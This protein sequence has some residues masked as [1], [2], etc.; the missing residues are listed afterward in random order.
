MLSGNA[1]LLE[2]PPKNL[3][4]THS[5]TESSQTNTFHFLIPEYSSQM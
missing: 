4:S 5:L 1:Y 2:Q 3:N